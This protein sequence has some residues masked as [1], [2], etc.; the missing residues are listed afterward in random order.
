[1]E[2]FFSEEDREEYLRL[3]AESGREHGVGI[4]GY[5]LMS[6]HVHLLVIPDDED[7]LAAG[8]GRAHERYTRGINFREG[9]R[10]YL[11]QGRFFSCP[12]DERGAMEVLRYIE[13]NPVR[14]GLVKR[15]EQWAWSS[16]GAHVKGRHDSVVKGRAFGMEGEE[17]K[18]FLREGTGEDELKRIRRH[19]RTGRPMGDDAFVDRV[20]R[21]LKRPLRRGKPGPKKAGR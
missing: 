13:L 19:V 11:W 1:M 5:C 8:L 7:S 17:W 14:A 18:E 21:M 10:G 12:L 15:A 20:E 16:A 6:N 2:V 9:W 4:L 3:L